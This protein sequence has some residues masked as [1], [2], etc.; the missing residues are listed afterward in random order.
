MFSAGF[1][2]DMARMMGAPP[3]VADAQAEVVTCALAYVDA[4]IS[5]ASARKLEAKGA[6]V[7]AVIEYRQ[8]KA[9]AEMAE[10]NPHA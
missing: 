8:A 1:V 3:C 6:L 2:G 7:A 5:R 4:V 10:E 9:R